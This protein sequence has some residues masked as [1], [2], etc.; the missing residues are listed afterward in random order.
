MKVVSTNQRITLEADPTR[1]S[2]VVYEML[3]QVK[4]SFPAASMVVTQV[5]I[6]VIFAPS[7]NRSKPKTRSFDISWPN[8]CSLRHDGNDK[9][10][11]QMLVDSGL[12]PR[13]SGF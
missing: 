1:N 8:S 9:I 11:R 10:I 3:A 13:V 6:V 4:K 2:L 12:E 7:P 5:G